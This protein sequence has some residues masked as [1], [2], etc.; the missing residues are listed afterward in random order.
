MLQCCH[1]AICQHAVMPGADAVLGCA[2]LCCPA[3]CCASA[4]QTAKPIAAIL[5]CPSA[6]SEAGSCDAEQAVY[7]KAG[8]SF[9]INTPD[10]TASKFWIGGAAQHGKVMLSSDLMPFQSGTQL[11]SGNWEEGGRAGE[12]GGGGGLEIGVTR[13]M[14]RV[15]ERG[16]G[17]YGGQCLN[18]G[19]AVAKLLQAH[20][21]GC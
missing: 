4:V 14:G 11:E 19:E 9:V 18:K 21:F 20:E 15:Q 12:G 5:Y 13:I 16:E 1:L 2:T 17:G 8:G 6:A 10:D 3:L 7:D